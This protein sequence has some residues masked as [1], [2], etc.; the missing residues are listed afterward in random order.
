V[1]RRRAAKAEE[2]EQR[3]LRRGTRVAPQLDA[4]A[5]GEAGPALLE[6]IERGEETR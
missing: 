3:G 6:D 5:G 2:G 4:H 1:L